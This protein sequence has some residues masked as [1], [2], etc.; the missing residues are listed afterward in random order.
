MPVTNL[1]RDTRLDNR[2]ELQAGLDRDW[3][4]CE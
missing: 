1:R 4:A 3:I 2:D